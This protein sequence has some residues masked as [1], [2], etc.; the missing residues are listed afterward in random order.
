VISVSSSSVIVRDFVIIW[1][2]LLHFILYLHQMTIVTTT[3]RGNNDKRAREERAENFSVE[4]MTEQLRCSVFSG[5][6]SINAA[7]PILRCAK[8]K[9]VLTVQRAKTN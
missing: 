9:V 1:H 3:I 2:F 4:K 7:A 6:S 8:T 5:G